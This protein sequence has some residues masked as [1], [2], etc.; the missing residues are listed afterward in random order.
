MTERVLEPSLDLETVSVN[1]LVIVRVRDI[2][3]IRPT[4]LASQGTSMMLSPSNTAP[5][6]LLLPRPFSTVGCDHVCTIHISC[7]TIENT[8][9]NGDWYGASQIRFPSNV[10]PANPWPLFVKPGG[11]ELNT[12]MAPDV[13]VTRTNPD[14]SAG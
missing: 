11:H 8:T 3:R 1:S 5:M 12:V 4:R 2:D 9:T 14:A 6:N 13:A 10:P 7:V